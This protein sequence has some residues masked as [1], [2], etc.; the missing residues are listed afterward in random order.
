MGETE[1]IRTA[2][3][4]ANDGTRPI[5]INLWPKLEAPIKP[6]PALEARIDEIL[7][8][9]SLEQK[10][11]QTI[12]ADIGSVTPE[13]I[14]T[15]PLGSIL[16]GG[17][18]APHGNMR[19]SREVWLA[20]ADAFWEASMHENGAGIPIMWGTDAVHGNNNVAGATIFPHNIGLGAS[21]D[22][23]LIERIGA[24]T[25]REVITAGFDWTF[26][27]TL[28]VVQDIRWGRTYESYSEDPNIVAKCGA[29]LINGLQGRLG[30]DAFLGSDKIIATVKHFIGDGGTLN[31]RDQ[32]D[33][34]ATEDELRDI[35][36]LGIEHA[37]SAGVQTVMASF[38]SWG[39]IK[40]HGRHDLL[41]ELLKDQWAFDGIL[42]GDWNGHAQ[43]SGASPEHAPESMTAGLD[44][45]MAPDSWKSLFHNTVTD[46]REGR[47]SPERL[48]DAVRRVLRVKL[49]SGLFDKPKPSARIPIQTA[50]APNNTAHKTL[51]QEAV[52]KSAVLLKNKD[53]ILPIN[54][55][56]HIL[57]AGAGADNLSMHC[58]GWSLSWQGDNIEKSDYPESET[59][60]EG[61]ARITRRN[62]SSY[63]YSETADWQKSGTSQKPDIAIYVFGERAYAEFRGDL[64]TL[65]FMPGDDHDITALRKL[66]AEGIPVVGVFLSGRPLW[67]NP[68]L[69]ACNAFI[70]AFL[71]GTQGGA[72]ADILL[73]QNG[74]YDFTA[75]L[76]FLWPMNADQ[77]ADTSVSPL[78]SRGFGLS[79]QDTCALPHLHE[80]GVETNPD[81]CTIFD[82]GN[83][84]SGW[85][86]NLEDTSGQT[87]WSPGTHTSPNEGLTASSADFGQQENAIR[88]SW[89]QAKG[90]IN[91]THDPVDFS[92]E[93]NADFLLTM[94]YFLKS[95]PSK[96]IFAEIVD[97]QGKGVRLDITDK[98]ETARHGDLKQFTIALKAITVSG[99][100]LENIT[101]VTL[102]SEGP[103]EIIITR[104]NFVPGVNCN[105]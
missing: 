60:L 45:F 23:E 46:V 66:R 94:D 12:Q 13:D 37:L 25:A 30:S 27:P 50:P 58:G 76:S 42:V 19:A 32:G 40:I 98:L 65:D 91:F 2:Q 57:V 67:V 35:H 72:L 75:K 36:S 83:T 17:N 56:H 43:L 1:K 82:K 5:D 38:S 6:D 8:S 59:I 70:A 74:E 16:N 39:D 104:M 4:V 80:S 44:I 54:S 48:D 64:N 18:S 68:E 52:R 29:A 87:I 21:A 88:I 100:D 63:I 22:A 24:A 11:G 71:P 86:A 20:L 85:S 89:S 77:Y 33:T 99:G 26:A 69:N 78:F 103:F 10:V 92:R 49:R 47:L 7:E 34:D 15:Y 84:V 31:G 3:S 95:K 61:I 79:L 93:A 101:R 53:S 55:A 96:P 97:T 105:A 102:A 28:A 9:L 14:R 41:T 62:N 51:A 90:Q 73:A 81:T